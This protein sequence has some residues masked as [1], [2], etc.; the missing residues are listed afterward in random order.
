M[1]CLL[2]KP[3]YF[4][5]R[6][7]QETPKHAYSDERF[8]EINGAYSLVSVLTIA[9]QQNKLNIQFMRLQ[10]LYQIILL[11]YTGN[12]LSAVL[13]LQSESANVYGT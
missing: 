6:G 3:V 10:V 7:L 8:M 12:S 1:N 9:G 4:S 11:Y 13:Y 2:G 5:L